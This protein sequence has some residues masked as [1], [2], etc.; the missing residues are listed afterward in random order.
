MLVGYIPVMSYLYFNVRGDICYI[1]YLQY[2]YLFFY[3][4]TQR[5]SE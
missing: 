4:R 5:L 3:F 2:L 1:L